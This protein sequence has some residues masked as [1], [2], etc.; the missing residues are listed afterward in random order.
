GLM[1]DGKRMAELRRSRAKYSQFVAR[2]GILRV[3]AD[4]RR[5]LPLPGAWGAHFSQPTGNNHD[6]FAL[7]AGAASSAVRTGRIPPGSPAE[8]QP[9]RRAGERQPRAGSEGDQG[10]VGAAPVDH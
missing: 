1:R 9:R 5:L 7:F 2:A 10:S 4:A 6:A 8:S 3:A